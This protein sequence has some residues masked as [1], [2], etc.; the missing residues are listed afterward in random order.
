MKISSLLPH[1]IEWKI[2]IAQTLE[3]KRPPSSTG[4]IDPLLTERTAAST[5]KPES[6]LNRLR[7][8]CAIFTELSKRRKDT[9]IAP[10]LR[11]TKCSQQKKEKHYKKKKHHKKKKAPQKH[12][13]RVCASSSLSR[14]TAARR[15][16]I[17]PASISSR[18]CSRL[19]PDC[20]IHPAV[21][22]PI[23]PTT[24]PIRP[25][26]W[27]PSGIRRDQSKGGRAG[28]GARRAFSMIQLCAPSQGGQSAAHGNFNFLGT[29]CRGELRG[30]ACWH[31]G[32]NQP[33]R[34]A[35]GAGRAWVAL[36]SS[37]LRQN[38]SLQRPGYQL[39]VLKYFCPCRCC[40]SSSEARPAMG[41]E[42]SSRSSTGSRAGLSA[43]EILQGEDFHGMSAAITRLASQE[44]SP[45]STPLEAYIG[46][47]GRAYSRLL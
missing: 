31:H 19:A 2:H 3:T 6:V 10:S 45:P 22:S 26:S 25:Q 11:P 23:R 27:I 8:C 41:D 35:A 37:P 47:R 43:I 24:P 13:P 20:A 12:K 40:Y 32:G 5:R 18:W 34:A 30:F 15:F 16:R 39:L 44:S 36:T 7:L 38:G 9:S 46:S 14:H 21:S 29:D 4:S 33:T 42:G 28:D 17:F 1:E